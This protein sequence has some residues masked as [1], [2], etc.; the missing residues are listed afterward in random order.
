M[1]GAR[2]TKHIFVPE[3]TR[4]AAE[5]TSSAP[6]NTYASFSA[7]VKTLYRA[8][9]LDGEVLE[10]G[11]ASARTLLPHIQPWAFN[12]A[13]DEGHVQA[14]VDALASRHPFFMGTFKFVCVGGER[15]F[16]IDGQHRHAALVQALA[17]DGLEGGD[18]R[19]I[20]EMYH[21]RD[22]PEG[23]SVDVA[24]QAL[25]QRAN[26]SL[27]IAPEHVPG[28]ALIDAVNML[29]S[30]P[31]LNPA[32]GR[33]NVVDLVALGTGQQRVN[34]PRISK[35][36]LANSMRESP[37]WRP[38]GL[39][40]M[41][42]EEIVR[43]VQKVNAWLSRMSCAELFGSEGDAFA[44]R[45]KAARSAGFFL[46]AGGRWPPERWIPVLLEARWR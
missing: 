17:D 1:D 41:P 21:L 19:L 23:A 39:A 4:R 22:I 26:N 14:M 25:F 46:N 11:R 5:R 3:P 12:R 13:L 34:R 37:A 2:A 9:V 40:S 36:A 29:C 8:R 42:P 28:D 16:L 45:L 24:V 7:H 33:A 35:K 32:T 27:N 44:R 30:D 43:R 6:D 10:L 38:D 15:V 20:V 31:T 18:V